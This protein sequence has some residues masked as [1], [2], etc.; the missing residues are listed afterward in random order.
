MDTLDRASWICSA[1][2]VVVVVG[3]MVVLLTGC[4]KP[5]PTPSPSPTPVASCACP[6]MTQGAGWH[7]TQKVE[8]GYNGI[9]INEAEQVLGSVCG[10][11]PDDSLA[12]LSAQLKD[13]G[14]CAGPWSGT[15][16]VGRPDGLWE[17]W[18]VLKSDTDGNC[19]NALVS[20]SNVATWEG[21]A[22]GCKQ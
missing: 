18:L 1:I 16:M 19:W 10:K 22:L 7:V 17:Q 21:P 12:K 2:M 6:D 9:F 4:P 11:P 20:D 13:M 5:Q 14:I 15:L 8:P 3:V